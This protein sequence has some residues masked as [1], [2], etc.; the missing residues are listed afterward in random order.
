MRALAVS[1]R[2]RTELW[3]ELPTIDASGVPGYD[4]SVW[5]G[6][7]ATAGTPPAVLAKLSSDLRA[8]V[9]E[10]ANKAWL[11]TQG[12]DAVG[13]SPVEFRAK[14]EREIQIW[15]ALIKKSGVTLE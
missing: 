14:I 13:D 5:Y 2:E 10:P 9:A 12:L 4:T 6:L 8:V 7:S 1:T 3:P 11:Q 15:A